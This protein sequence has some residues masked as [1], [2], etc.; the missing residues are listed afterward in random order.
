MQRGRLAQALRDAV[1][2]VPGVSRLVGSGVVE[3]AAQFPGGKVPGV[4]MGGDAPAVYIA[5]SRLPVAPVAEAALSAAEQAMSAAG[6]DRRVRIV[7]ADL[8]VDS[9]P[10]QE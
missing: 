5:V 9:L 4:D 7:V 1:T 8:D 2:A 3:V 10:E 6:D